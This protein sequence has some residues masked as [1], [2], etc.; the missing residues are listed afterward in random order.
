MPPTS[1][2]E[3]CLHRKGEEDASYV[4][5]RQTPPSSGRRCPPTSGRGKCDA[6]FAELNDT[7]GAVAQG[8]VSQMVYRGPQDSAK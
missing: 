6:C 7:S 5:D 2:I 3:R 1:G 8:H 4:R